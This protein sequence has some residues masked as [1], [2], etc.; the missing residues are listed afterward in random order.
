M[1]AFVVGTLLWCGIGALSA[2]LLTVVM[3]SDAALALSGL[4]LVVLSVG[5]ALGPFK[6]PMVWSEGALMSYAGNESPDDAGRHPGRWRL[7]AVPAFAFAAGIVLLTVA[8]L[9]AL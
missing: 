6:T 5:R 9:L 8:G 7:I 2:G 1:T 3:T 4:A